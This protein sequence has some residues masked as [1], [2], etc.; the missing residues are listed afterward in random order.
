MESFDKF[1]PDLISSCE[2]A[3]SNAYFFHSNFR[4]GAAV[5]TPKGK[6]FSG[7]SVDNSIYGLTICAERSAILKVN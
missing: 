7:A 3:K 5:L 1:M 4:V 6:I 2:F